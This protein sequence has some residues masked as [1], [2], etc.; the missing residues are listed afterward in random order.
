MQGGA[1][2][3]LLRPPQWHG[4]MHDS[5]RSR[6]HPARW[7]HWNVSSYFPERQYSMQSFIPQNAGTPHAATRPHSP[8][9]R[10]TGFAG[11]RDPDV[12]ASAVGAPVSAVVAT[13]TA[14][15][16]DGA[17]VRPASAEATSTASSPTAGEATTA[18]VPARGTGSD[19]P[20]PTAAIERITSAHRPWST[21][22]P[23]PPAIRLPGG[24]CVDDT[25]RA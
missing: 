1:K 7:R 22:A 21:L 8:P 13:A 15:A 6:M 3:L 18:V 24:V 16:D 11:G 14:G 19:R 12:D 4:S 10:S 25:W 2:L 9:Q 17:G 20:H 23:C 5:T